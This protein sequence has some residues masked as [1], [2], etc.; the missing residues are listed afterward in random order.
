MAILLF[1][2][3]VVCPQCNTARKVLCDENG[4]HEEVYCPEC[5]CPCHDSYCEWP[6][7]EQ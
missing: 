3:V 5:D 2:V 1:Y 7:V 6:P 4:D